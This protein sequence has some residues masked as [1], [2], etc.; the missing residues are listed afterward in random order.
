[1]SDS[2]DALN[3]LIARLSTLAIH[4]PRD[5]AVRFAVYHR[6]RQ[7]CEY[8]LMAVGADFELDH[9]IPIA[10]WGAYSSGVYVDF[11][12]EMTRP[13]P[14]HLSN[15][16]CAC[17]HC[18]A[19]KGQQVTRRV[20]TGVHRLFDPRRDKWPDHFALAYE[21]LIIFGITSIGE[22]TV[23]ALALNDQ[24]TNNPLGHRLGLRHVMICQRRYPPGWAAD[25]R[26]RS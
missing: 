8:C 22:A 6:A 10:R 4:G 12:L 13:G 17:Q 14:N 11:G 16:A 18:N 19:A 25:W 24:Q 9:V 26:I 5:A 2:V 1:M 7:V 23:E 20:R 15:F 21:A 3:L